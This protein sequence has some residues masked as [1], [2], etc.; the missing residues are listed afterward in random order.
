MRRDKE[1]RVEGKSKLEALGQ[2]Y[3]EKER[4]KEK[5]RAGERGKE[6]WEKRGD[7]G[8]LVGEVLALQRKNLKR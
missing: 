8:Q 3:G 1:E 2:E 4:E 6:W 5:E 7:R